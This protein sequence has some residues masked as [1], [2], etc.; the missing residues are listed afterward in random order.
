MSYY[1][2]I[3][4]TT[5]ACMIYME[6]DTGTSFKMVTIQL[7]HL[8]K[9][10]HIVSIK[11]LTFIVNLTVKHFSADYWSINCIFIFFKKETQRFCFEIRRA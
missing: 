10:K 9:L 2:D 1:N 7:T 11:L 5:F 3:T 6:H 4:I 8:F